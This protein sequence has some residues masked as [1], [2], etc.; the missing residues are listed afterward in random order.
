MLCALSEMFTIASLQELSL[1][2]V[3]DNINSENIRGL[4]SFSH[5]NE[6]RSLKQRCLQYIREGRPCN[7]Q[8]L[9][10]Q[11]PNLAEDILANA[12]L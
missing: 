9:C 1:R 2:V 5:Y 11:L 8:L 4:L 12:P 10:Q 3:D 6:V 7:I